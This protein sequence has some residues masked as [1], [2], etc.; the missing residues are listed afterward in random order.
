MTNFVNGPFGVKHSFHLDFV[1]FRGASPPAPRSAGGIEGIEDSPQSPKTVGVEH[2]AFHGRLL[3]PSYLGAYEH[4]IA[5]IQIVDASPINFG[6]RCGPIT[7]EIFGKHISRRTK[8]ERNASH[9]D[10]DPESPSPSLTVTASTIE[11]SAV[12]L[13]ESVPLHRLDIGGLFNIAEGV[14]PI[15]ACRALQIRRFALRDGCSLDGCMKIFRVFNNNAKSPMWQ[16][17]KF[18]YIRAAC[19]PGVWDGYNGARSFSVVSLDPSAERAAVVSSSWKTLTCLRPGMRVEVRRPLSASSIRYLAHKRLKHERS[20]AASYRHYD[21]L[22][23][24]VRSVDSENGVADIAL[25]PQQVMVAIHRLDSFI[26]VDGNVSGTLKSAPERPYNIDDEVVGPACCGGNFGFGLRVTGVQLDAMLIQGIDVDACLKPVAQAV[27]DAV[28][29]SAPSLLRPQS[30][31][32]AILQSSEAS[33]LP[34]EPPSASWLHCHACKL[35]GKRSAI[36][37][38]FKTLNSQRGVFY[39]DVDNDGF[40]IALPKFLAQMRKQA[41]MSEFDG[42]IPA[43]MQQPTPQHTPGF[44]QVGIVLG[45]NSTIQIGLQLR[46]VECL[47]LRLEP[48]IQIDAPEAELTIWTQNVRHSN[49][50]RTDQVFDRLK[51]GATGIFFKLTPVTL[52]QDGL[53]SFAVKA[54]MTSD[55][56]STH[57]RVEL[58]EQ[59]MTHALDWVTEYSRFVRDTHE[60]YLARKTPTE[61][62]ALPFTS[63]HINLACWGGMCVWLLCNTVLALWIL[64]AP[65]VATVISAGVCSLYALF[66]RSA[67]RQGAH[68]TGVHTF[69]SAVLSSEDRSEES[70]QESPRPLSYKISVPKSQRIVLAVTLPTAPAWSKVFTLL[71]ETLKLQIL[72]QLFAQ[73]EELAVPLDAVVD[74]DEESHERP[75]SRTPDDSNVQTAVDKMQHVSAITSELHSSLLPRSLAML[76]PFDVELLFPLSQAMVLIQPGKVVSVRRLTAVWHLLTVAARMYVGG[77]IFLAGIIAGLFIATVLQLCF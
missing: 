28:V 22:P 24:I 7:S 57:V 37:F 26:D 69:Q 41:V 3:V 18:R 35:E 31:A 56:D 46:V 43:H 72:L 1:G 74:D 44:V 16:A 67:S 45:C 19:A 47:K 60:E 38:R 13:A 5:S 58:S 75:T 23:A 33:Q 14:L 62:S 4:T 10:C 52:Q 70:G 39:E 48:P 29:G 36:L 40:P 27:L 71:E 55:P 20:P 11:Q 30:K 2:M 15:P 12:I 17:L 54:G 77:P 59:S 34:T 25:V 73:G 42:V 51:F 21:W 53:L 64:R 66:G 6:D 32:E 61:A 50:K 68:A 49:T 76:S 9:E 63:R 65:Y 8:Y